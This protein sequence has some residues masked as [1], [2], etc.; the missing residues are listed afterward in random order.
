MGGVL[1]LKAAAYISSWNML[2]RTA[3]FESLGDVVSSGIMTAAQLKVSST[4][5]QHHYPLG[6]RRIAPLG[7]LFF[8][9]FMCSA[10]L[11][12][13]IESLSALFAPQETT[14]NPL[15]SFLEDRPLLRGFYGQRG[16]S[17]LL[18]EYSPTEEGDSASQLILSLLG[19]CALVKFLLYLFCRRVARKIGSDIVQALY[20]DHGNDTITNLMVMGIMVFSGHLRSKFEDPPAWIDKIEP[21]ASLLLA[22]WIIYGWVLQALEQLSVLSDRR[23]DMDTAPVEKAIGG[24]MADAP[25][26]L[27]HVDLLQVGDGFH[28]VMHVRPV[29]DHSVASKITTAFEAA[30]K[31]VRQVNSDVREVD[32]RLR[33]SHTDNWVS[34]YHTI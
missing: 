16:I 26:A 1:A 5:D 21:L 8:A 17:R 33:H 20:I 4:R 22:L 15:Q 32:V 31:A 24:A 18:D 11:G 30:A 19:L 14:L 2:V 34:A 9:A 23:A 10:M 29:A 12:M 27:S 3:A 7:A 6:K 13:V 28:A 25:V